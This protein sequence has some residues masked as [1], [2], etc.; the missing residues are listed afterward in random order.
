MPVSA[1]IDHGAKPSY[2]LIDETG[3]LVKSLEWKP[4]RDVTEKKN[5]NQQVIYYSARN[6]RLEGSIKGPAVPASGGALEGLA[7]VH[8]GV[9]TAIA[10]FGTGKSVHGF[11]FA[12]GNKVIIKDPTQS[13]S[14]EEEAQLDIPFVFLPGISTYD[15]ATS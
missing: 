13:L 3:M 11:A 7:I 4:M 2:D 12:S 14:E 1:T 15:D 5:A 9:A 10:N 8:P 6:P